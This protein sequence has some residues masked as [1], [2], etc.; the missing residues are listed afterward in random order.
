MWLPAPV[1][2]QL[3]DDLQRNTVKGDR[4]SGW[5]ARHTE[6]GD[7]HLMSHALQLTEGRASLVWII[8]YLGL[9]QCSRRSSHLLRKITPAAAPKRRADPKPYKDHVKIGMVD[10][11]SVSVEETL[12]HQ[13][14]RLTVDHSP[15]E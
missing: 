8:R 13:F 1:T 10:L 9:G 3:P 5:G 2:L 14:G 6:S 11:I 12:C 4:H 15:T 7:G